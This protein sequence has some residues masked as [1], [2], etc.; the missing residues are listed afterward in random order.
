[1]SMAADLG[2]QKGGSAGTGTDS[3]VVE[4]LPIKTAPRRVGR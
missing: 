4:Q 1:M 2:Q 3:A